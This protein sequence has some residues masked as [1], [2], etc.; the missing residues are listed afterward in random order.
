MML[1]RTIRSGA[2]PCGTLLAWAIDRG[3]PTLKTASSR[4]RTVSKLLEADLRWAAVACDPVAPARHDGRLL[5]TSGRVS[6]L[7]QESVYGLLDDSGTRALL[8]RA[9][10]TYAVRRRALLRELRDRGI[11]AHAR[12]GMNVWVPVRD[13]SAAV[14]GLRSY[15]WWVAAGAR[16]RLSSDPGVRITVAELEPVDTA[17]LAS[18]FAT[19]LGESEATY[20][21]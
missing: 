13:E 8:A 3:R 21:G 2:S 1:L 19:V 17:R 10:E 7:L 18:D 4:K 6:H 5:L 11:E 16:F 14:N 9:Q 15:G 12:S 20:R